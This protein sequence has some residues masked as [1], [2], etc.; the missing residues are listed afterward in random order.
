M[1]FLIM[2]VLLLLSGCANQGLNDTEVP[3]ILGVSIETNYLCKKGGT[4]VNCLLRNE[5]SDVITVKVR[6]QGSDDVG[7]AGYYITPE[8]SLIPANWTTIVPAGTTYDGHSC[9]ASDAGRRPVSAKHRSD[10]STTR[11]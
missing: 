6:I 2:L 5:P 10:H 1:H 7:I 3:K 11:L 4:E 8:D 9:R